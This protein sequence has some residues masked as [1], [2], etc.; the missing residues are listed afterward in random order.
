[1]VEQ[2][3]ERYDVTYPGGEARDAERPWLIG[4]PDGFL[5]EYRTRVLLEVKTAGVHAHRGFEG[6]PFHYQA[7]V[8]LYLHLTGLHRALVAIL[9]GGQRLE[10]HELGRDERAIRGLLDLSERFWRYVETNEPPP[11]D[12]SDS[13]REAMATMFPE[14]KPGRTVRLM[15]AAWETYRELRRRRAQM[16]VLKR[17]VAELENKLKATMGDAER[18]IGPHDED[19]LTWRTTEAKRIDV[20]RLR[21]DRPEIAAEYETATPTRRFVVL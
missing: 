17:Q 19:A 18:A 12:S 13:T 21:R 15:G 7:Q 2:L 16:D 10:L 9:V 14:H 3:R 20:T 1:V 5:N 11:P 4:H 8:Q 6:V